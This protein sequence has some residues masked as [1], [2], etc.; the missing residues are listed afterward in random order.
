MDLIG[1]VS[2]QLVSMRAEISAQKTR[3]AELTGELKSL[4]KQLKDEYGVDSIEAAETLLVEYTEQAQE[5]E[6]Q[7]KDCME[8]LEAVLYGD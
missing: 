4:Y 5:L 2:E 7:L 6:M 1:N 8:K 3:Q